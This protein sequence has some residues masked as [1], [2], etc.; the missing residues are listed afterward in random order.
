MDGSNVSVM[1]TVGQ[2]TKQKVHNFVEY[3]KTNLDLPQEVVDQLTRLDNMGEVALL[4]AFKGELLPHK[5]A[6]LNRD[7]HALCFANL[8]LQDCMNSATEEQREK[9]W[10]YLNL[11]V[12][13]AEIKRKEA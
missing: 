13:I 4:A 8:G 2:L 11:F 3:C 7:E 9:V 5:Q 6:I 12:E 1:V 10:Q